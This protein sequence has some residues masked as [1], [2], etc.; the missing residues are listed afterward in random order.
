[1]FTR[2][3]AKRTAEIP[4]PILNCTRAVHSN[5]FVAFRVFLNFSIF[6]SVYNKLFVAVNGPFAEKLLTHLLV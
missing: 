1:M 5:L 3:L 4:S 6:P 2:T